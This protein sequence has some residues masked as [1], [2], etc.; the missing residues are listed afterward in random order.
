MTEEALCAADEIGEG[1]ARAFG[2]F[3]KTRRKAFVV[4]RNG[5][6]YAWWDRCPHFDAPIAW[7]ANQ[8]L[9]A[10]RDRIVC[11]AHGAEFEIETGVCVLGAALSSR[12]APAPIEMTP[13]GILVFRRPGED[14]A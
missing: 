3:D 9:N 6:F 11:A 12:L 5:R 4:R 7:R 10:A 1:E 8:Y 2:P 14:I 13:E